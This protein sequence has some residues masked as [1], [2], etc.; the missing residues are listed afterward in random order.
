MYLISLPCPLNKPFLL[1]VIPISSVAGRGRGEEEREEEIKNG[2]IAGGTTNEEEKSDRYSIKREICPV[3]SR[4]NDFLPPTS[5]FPFDSFQDKGGEGGYLP[6][7]N[8][9]ACYLPL[10]DKQKFCCWIIFL[11]LIFRNL[12]KLEILTFGWLWMVPFFF[13]LFSI[14]FVLVIIFIEDKKKELIFYHFMRHY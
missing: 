3:I 8:H 4:V 7:A 10:V 2:R 9:F 12:A 6:A 5:C 1:P 11:N 13:N 14:F